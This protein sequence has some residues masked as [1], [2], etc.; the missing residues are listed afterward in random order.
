MLHRKD[1]FVSSVDCNAR[2]VYMCVYNLKLYTT[3]FSVDHRTSKSEDVICSSWVNLVILYL[4]FWFSLETMN[5][6]N[7]ENSIWHAFDYLAV[8]T[9]RTYA[10][11]S[12]LKVILWY[13][14][15]SFPYHQSYHRLNFVL[16]RCWQRT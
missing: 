5:K 9:G 8:E 10:S 2:N 15:P 13:L 11:K 4:N 16:D 14:N 12:K 3:H 1:S 7:V 6:L